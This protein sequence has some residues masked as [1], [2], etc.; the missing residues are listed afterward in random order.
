VHRRARPHHASHLPAPPR[1]LSSSRLAPRRVPHCVAPRAHSHRRVTPP[2]GSHILALSRT[3]S[4]GIAP[5]R[6]APRH[7]SP[8]LADLAPLAISRR[9]AARNAAP[10]RTTPPHTA[11]AAPHR[12]T[13]RNASHL[14]HRPTAGSARDACI[15]DG[16]GKRDLPLH[17]R[18]LRRTPDLAALCHPPY[19]ATDEC[20]AFPLDNIPKNP[21][22]GKGPSASRTSSAKIRKNNTLPFVVALD[23]LR[24][25]RLACAQAL[26]RDMVANNKL[27]CAPDAAVLSLWEDDFL[28]YVDDAK[29]RG[30]LPPVSSWTALAQL[31]GRH[32]QDGWR[33]LET[34]S[35]PN[36]GTA[37]YCATCLLRDP[38][39]CHRHT[40]ALEAPPSR[41][42]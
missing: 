1:T 29:A 20:V 15:A 38:S 35:R 17:T 6:T 5:H 23:V 22:A 21:G 36:A 42:R 27:E 32:G 40:Q 19:T 14:S 12:H 13:P 16:V 8:H 28:T 11:R 31:L 39:T 41:K 30:E 25:A 4:H 26:V 10:R 3:A 2:T 9:V 37:K 34:A 33:V 24:P 7:T 18:A